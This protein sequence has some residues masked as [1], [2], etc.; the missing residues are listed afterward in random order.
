MH[1]IISEFT[2]YRGGQFDWW[3]IR[4]KSPAQV[5]DTL[6]NKGTCSKYKWCPLIVRDESQLVQ[7]TGEKGFS[8]VLI[9]SSHLGVSMVRKN[10]GIG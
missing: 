10:V 4:R 7:R 6:Y 8:S 9:M 5:T 1:A 2:V 3:I